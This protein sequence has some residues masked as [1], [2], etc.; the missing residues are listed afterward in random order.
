MLDMSN[1]R[2]VDGL[3][4]INTLTFTVWRL[5]FLVLSDSPSKYSETR[6]LAV[7][8]LISGISPNHFMSRSFTSAFTFPKILD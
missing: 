1:F 3:V 8:M 6:A 2:D 5:D 4:S 7:S